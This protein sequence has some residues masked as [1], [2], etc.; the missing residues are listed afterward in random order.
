MQLN[1]WHSLADLINRRFS[2]GRRRFDKIHYDLEN[3]TFVRYR[4][5]KP[6]WRLSRSEFITKY[7]RILNNALGPSDLNR[8]FA[9]SFGE[10]E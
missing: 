5:K 4:I 8:L 10:Q 7:Y 9:W 3:N 1:D 2:F 6:A